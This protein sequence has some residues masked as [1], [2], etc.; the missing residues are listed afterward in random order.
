MAAR[1][2]LITAILNLSNSSVKTEWV[3]Q[4]KQR[5][6][7]VETNAVIAI[8][9]TWGRSLEINKAVV[10]DWLKQHIALTEVVSA[11]S[12]AEETI[13]SATPCLFPIR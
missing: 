9:G 4:V 2:A 8:I 10:P 13:A 6:R 3:P 12:R 11:S 7:A 5:R 1:E